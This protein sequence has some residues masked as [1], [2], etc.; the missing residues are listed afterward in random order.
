MVGHRGQLEAELSSARRQGKIRDEY[1]PVVGEDLDVVT[2][3]QG[4]VKCVIGAQRGTATSWFVQ[5]NQEYRDF[6][7]EA[8]RWSGAIVSVPDPESRSLMGRIV[9]VAQTFRWNLVQPHD[10]PYF[11]KHEPGLRPVEH[12]GR[13]AQLKKDRIESLRKWLTVPLVS[14]VIAAA[15]IL[16]RSWFA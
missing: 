14:A 10:C 3:L 11:V 8:F 9:G 15:V 16:L 2:W 1:N 4:G 13:R 6:S 7:R 12:I 5:G